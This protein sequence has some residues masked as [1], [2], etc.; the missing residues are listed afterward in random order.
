MKSKHRRSKRIRRSRR[1]RRNK[2]GDKV[3]NP[4]TGRY[5]SAHGKTGREIL[6]GKHVKAVPGMP[7]DPTFSGVVRKSCDSSWVKKRKIGGGVI[8]STYVVCKAG[9][10]NYVLKIQ[11]LS[12]GDFRNEVFMLTL[13]QDKPYIPRIYDAWT[14]KG[15]GYLVLEKLSP[16]TSLSR[17]EKYKQLKKIIKDLHSMKIILNDLKPDNVMYKNGRVMLI[18]FGKIL[19]YKNS[20]EKYNHFYYGKIDMDEAKYADLLT[21]EE[22]WGSPSMRKEAKKILDDWADEAGIL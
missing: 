17:E 4:K 19:K 9:S 8:G 7:L 21:L 11:R 16:R 2:N 14:C 5:V 10:C 22:H 15:K 12:D 3:L 6:Y 1:S 18:D 13:L 20:K